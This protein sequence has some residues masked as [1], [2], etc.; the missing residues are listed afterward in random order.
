[1]TF[2]FDNIEVRSKNG[3]ANKSF[4]TGTGTR[5]DFQLKYSLDDT[6]K[7]KFTV[8]LKTWNELGLDEGNGLMF[9]QVADESGRK[10]VVVGLVK[11]DDNRCALF[12]T[13]KSKKGTKTKSTHSRNLEKDL[14]DVRVLSEVDKATIV[15]RK[16]S[17]QYLEFST[18]DQ[19]NLPEGVQK[20]FEVVSASSSVPAVD[21][22]EEVE[23]SD[24]GQAPEEEPVNEAEASA[25]VESEDVPSEDQPA[26][27]EAPVEKEPTLDDEF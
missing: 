3:K 7:S 23:G 14:I 1:M 26:V 27:E 17:V 16:P 6:G 13:S 12:P 21:T 11:E 19:D 25:S 5:K 24:Q 18:I 4:S 8:S 15:K 2:N 22:N 10:A 20:M 9:A